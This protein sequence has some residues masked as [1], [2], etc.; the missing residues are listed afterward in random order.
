M[1]FSATLKN[2]KIKNTVKKLPGYN[3]SG[4]I[5]STFFIIPDYFL[6]AVFLSFSVITV[7]YQGKDHGI[8]VAHAS[9]DSQAETLET[10]MGES[11]E[12]IPSRYFFSFSAIWIAICSE[13]G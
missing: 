13:D 11:S 8:K 5:I 12:D 9:S 3:K 4:I 6:P 7:P 10:R 2:L 1:T